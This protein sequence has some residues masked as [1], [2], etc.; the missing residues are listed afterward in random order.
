MK[1]YVE[2][3]TTKEF[4]N[5]FLKDIFF[6]MA[7]NR[8]LDAA[9]ASAVVE[10]K[11]YESLLEKYNELR[12]NFVDYVCSGVP[13]PAPYCLNKCKECTD[14]HGWCKYDSEKCKGFNP[15]YFLI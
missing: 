3:N 9:P 8:V 6:R 10:A 7:V 15:A 13:N 4:A 1:K 2:V 14:G 12:E 11:Q 5:A